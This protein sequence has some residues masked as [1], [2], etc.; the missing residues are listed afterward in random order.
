MM[1]VYNDLVD[2]IHV[3]SCSMCDDFIMISFFVFFQPPLVP[4]VLAA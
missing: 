3:T 4:P 2:S 1:I